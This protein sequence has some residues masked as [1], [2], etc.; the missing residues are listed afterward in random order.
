VS[1]A[2]PGAGLYGK[3]PARGDFVA[4]N[5]PPSFVN[6]W[7]GWLAASIAESRRALGAAWLERFLMAPPWRFALSPG[8][9]GATGWLGV[10]ATSVDAVGRAFPLTLAAALPEGLGLGRLTGDPTAALDRLERLALALIDGGRDPE[11]AAAEIAASG[12][13][14]VAASAAPVEREA[15]GPAEAG[16]WATTGRPEASVAVRLTMTARAAGFDERSL[17]WHEGWAGGAPRTLVFVGLP[18]PSL[19]ATFL[20]GPAAAG[21][22]ALGGVAAP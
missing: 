9:A 13:A 14:A 5:L 11:L 3:L 6:A 2:A 4:R 21:L 18:S 10:M 12:E 15:V 22:P 8:L 17:W 16:G 19:F 1:R 20:G 7:D